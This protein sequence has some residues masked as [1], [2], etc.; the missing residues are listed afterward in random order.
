M[1]YTLRYKAHGGRKYFTNEDGEVAIAD[2]SIRD[3][4]NPETTD[5]GLVLIDF[6]RMPQAKGKGEYRVF[7]KTGAGEPT[8]FSIDGHD[9]ENVMNATQRKFPSPLF[10]AFLE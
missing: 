10:G 2:L 7:A 9:L 1:P 5:D 8:A 6:S 4:S 3:E